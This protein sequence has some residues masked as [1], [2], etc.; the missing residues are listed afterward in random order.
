[1]DKK[2]TK[3][4]KNIIWTVVS[5]LLAALTIRMVFKQ[6][7][8]MSAGDLM[9]VIQSADKVWLLLAVAASAAYVWFEGVAL[10]AILKY[11]GY[12][13]SPFR[14]LLYST[15]DVY[16]SAITPSATGGQP[17]S[18]YF[19][20]KDGIPAGMTTSVLVLNLMMYTLSVVALGILSIA[21]SPDA[22]FGFGHISRLLIGIGFVTLSALSVFFLLLLKKGDIIF[23]PIFS[24]VFFL[25]D[26]GLLRNKEKKRQRLEKIRS[27]YK[28]SSDLISGKKRIVFSAFVWN[29]IQRGSQFLVPMLV[30]R[31]LGGETARMKMI[32]SKQCLITIGFN[33]VPI[34]G[35]MGV[36]DYL[37]LDG[38]SR[39]MEET[40]AYHVE[41]ISRGI[42][43]YICVAISGL[44]TLLG[45]FLISRR[46]SAK[47][48]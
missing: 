12:P 8:D 7:N 9:A 20:I 15:S 40:M 26:K 35:G 14:G 27:D 39:V 28:S 45:Y 37:M 33:F 13:R 3:I 41:L 10:C 47:T 32:F 11:A 5:V 16:F 46:R 43:F 25:C 30:Y 44:I 36:S 48:S 42:T 1:M 23:V 29:F 21:I 4:N 17:A 6:N 38:F 2:D 18:A 22:V 24:I 34:P 31:S 19:M